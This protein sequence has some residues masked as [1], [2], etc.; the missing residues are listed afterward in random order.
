MGYARFITQPIAIFIVRKSSSFGLFFQSGVATAYHHSPNLSVFNIRLLCTNFPISS[1]TTSKNLLFGLP[2]FLFPNNSI[3]IIF[4]P[5]YSWSLLMT[6][7][8]HL[9]LPSLI[10]IPNHSTLTVLLMYLFLILSFLVTPIANFNIFI[11]ATSISSTCFFVTTTVSSPY[12]I[13]GLTTEL[14]TFPFILAGNLLSQI[15]PDTLFHPFHSACTL[16]FTSL[17]HPPLSCTVN[18]KY[19]NSFT[20]GTFVSSIFIVSLSFHP[21][22]HRYSVSDLLTFILLLSNA[23]LQDSN[24]CSI[25]SLVFSQITISSANSIVHGGS[26]LISSVNLSIITV[27]RK[28]LNADPWCSPTL[29][30]KLSVIPT[31]HLT[32]VLLPSYISCT[33]CTYFSAIPDFLI[34]YHSFSRGTRRKLFLGPRVHNVV[35][36]DLPSTFPSTFLKQTWHRWFPFLA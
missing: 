13:A 21:F 2:L 36:F 3:S 22:M 14:Y 35:L 9:S 19:L 30:L 25:S 34:Q 5:T 10:F 23:Y 28:G 11:S 24:L 29:T 32:T 27:N 18:S 6:C 7:P 15:T 33:S 26:L 1:F 16:F 8:Y 20:L 17:S 12:T 4:L 31:A